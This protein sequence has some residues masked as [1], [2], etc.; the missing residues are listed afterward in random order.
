MPCD[1]SVGPAERQAGLRI[2]DANFN[3]A[4]EGL[5][6]VEDHCRFALADAFLTKRCKHLRHN[7]V[8]AIRSISPA[9]LAA[10]RESAA[11]VGAAIKTPTEGERHSLAHIA[12]A[13]WQR[14][15]QALRVIEEVLKLLAP[16]A[17]TSVEALRYEAY[18]LDKACRIN[19]DSRERL[20]SA[21]LYVLIAG[22]NS[23]CAFVERAQE[24]IAAG[25]HVLQLRDKRLDERTLLS[26]ARLLRRV[27]DD[28]HD[29]ARQ[30]PRPADSR[31][32]T[33]DSRPP[34]LILNDRP[35]LAV[36]ARADGVHVGQEELSVHD[37][38]QIVGP[39]MLIGVSTHDV[40]QARQAVLD[41]ASYIGCGPTFPSGTKAFERLSGLEFLRQVAAEI[42][43]PAFA[44]GG[45]TKE[46][47]P[48]V[49]ATG[50]T[51]VAIGGAAGE[52]EEILRIVTN[53]TPH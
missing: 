45:I 30:E 20:A 14:V 22:G 37:A 19:A 41:G 35:D 18:T 49:M 6:V 40:E 11:D 5:R 29:S 7:L 31:L 25:A 46:N 47:V 8:A 17:A 10:A 33:P 3:R 12:A 26:R 38:R 43:L 9:V 4:T 53:S 28:H 2:L 16:E 36:L 51:R 42:S 39:D 32:P 15:Q 1:N 24:L 27:I 44:I 23:E 34:L 13:S 52:A 50:L 48:Q 21:R